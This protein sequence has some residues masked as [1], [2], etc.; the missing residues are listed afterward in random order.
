M[1]FRHGTIITKGSSRPIF[2]GYNTP[3]TK[4]L[5]YINYCQHAEMDVA[6]KLYKHLQKKCSSSNQ[7]RRLTRK[8]ITWVGRIS[9]TDEI[10]YSKPCKQCRIRLMRMGFKKI[11]YTDN[12]SK[13]HLVN[14]DTIQDD[15]LSNC[16]RRIHELDVWSY[17]NSH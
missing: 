14:I 13:I 2:R 6:A 9:K 17:K 5:N 3:R 12:D 16:Q 7:L 1:N 8:Y 15:N 4:Y 11:G 10:A